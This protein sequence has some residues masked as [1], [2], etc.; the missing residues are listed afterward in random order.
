MDLL[1]DTTGQCVASLPP[2]PVFE[3]GSNGKVQKSDP[4]TGEPVFSIEVVLYQDTGAEVLPVKF[5]G[6]PPVG[7]KC[8]SALKV[9]GLVAS[10]WQL[11]GGK[12]GLSFKA[13]KVELA[14]GAA[15][16]KAAS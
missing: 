10:T 12:H 2:K 1:L 9:T 4:E 6:Q 11:E 7:V 15:G 8:G 13:A 5:T 3:F 16:M 14:A